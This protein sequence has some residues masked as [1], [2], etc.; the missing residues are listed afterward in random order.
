MLKVLPDEFKQELLKSCE[1]FGVR[2][3][4]PL[5]MMLRE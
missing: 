2:R 4:P 1:A 3:R 5:F